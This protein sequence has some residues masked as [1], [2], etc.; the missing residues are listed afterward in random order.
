MVENL[1]TVWFDELL[2]GLTTTQHSDLLR[3]MEPKAKQAL[4]EAVLSVGRNRYACR[5]IFHPGMS[6]SNYLAERLLV[7]MKN[8]LTVCFFASFL[9]LLFKK[10][11]QLFQSDSKTALRALRSILWQYFRAALF[12]CLGA[13]LPFGLVCRIPFFSHNWARM[14]FHLRAIFL[15]ALMPIAC[16]IVDIP[17]KMPAYM[18]FYVSKAI[19][20]T[21]LYTI[22][23]A[24]LKPSMQ[25]SLGEGH[26]QVLSFYA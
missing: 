2:K 12:L 11:K 15:Y 6:C 1:G 23:H 24:G 21:D 25:D 14:P 5:D 20:I 18:G 3:T 19:S 7:T 17:T 16:L 9:P 13:G 8:G 10:R 26:P 4:A 22:Q